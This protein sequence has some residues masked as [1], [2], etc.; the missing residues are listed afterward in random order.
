MLALPFSDFPGPDPALPT[1]GANWAW[2]ILFHLWGLI[3]NPGLYV[4]RQMR[5][6]LLRGT[7]SNEVEEID[8]EKMSRAVNRSTVKTKLIDALMSKNEAVNA[9]SLLIER[10]EEM[11]T[12]EELYQHSRTVIRAL[13]QDNEKLLDKV[14]NEIFGNIVGAQTSVKLPPSALPVIKE[15]MAPL[16]DEMVSSIL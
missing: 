10:I 8:T 4:I 14:V 11:Y 15:K 2:T 16:I 3:E 9:F 1:I 7:T 5:R 13:E 12:E 6:G